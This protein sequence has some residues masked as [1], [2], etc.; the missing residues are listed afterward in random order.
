LPYAKAHFFVFV[1]SIAILDY[2]KRQEIELSDR[3]KGIHAMLKFNL[4]TYT[5]QPIPILGRVDLAAV[6]LARDKFASENVLFGT[7]CFVLL[8]FINNRV[9]S[10]IGFVVCIF[11]L[12]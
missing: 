6:F 9:F 2:H 7:F 3:C 11:A 5:I 8:C 4:L 10:I 1:L 12:L